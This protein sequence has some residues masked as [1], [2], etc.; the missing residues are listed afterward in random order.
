MNGNYTLCAMPHN[1]IQQILEIVVYLL[2]MYCNFIQND[3]K[4]DFKQDD[5]TYSDWRY[6]M[7]LSILSVKQTNDKEINN[8]DEVTLSTI[9]MKWNNKQKI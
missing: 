4:L 9:N 2:C 3:C 7:I 6:K 5:I 8:D 1:K